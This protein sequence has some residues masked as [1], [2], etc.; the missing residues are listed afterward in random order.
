MQQSGN[1]ARGQLG[2]TRV[3]SIFLRPIIP[4]R[5]SFGWW[6]MDGRKRGGAEGDESLTLG[7]PN[8]IYLVR[9]EGQAKRTCLASRSLS[10]I[11]HLSLPNLS[12]SLLGCILRFSRWPIYPSLPPNTALGGICWL[13]I[14]GDLH[15]RLHCFNPSFSLTYRPRF[16]RIGTCRNWPHSPGPAL[17]HA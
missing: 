3:W 8:A 12:F 13:S 15:H 2:P 4:D 17:S 7:R 10:V 9:R 11:L 16:F 1:D 6:W 5:L 14:H